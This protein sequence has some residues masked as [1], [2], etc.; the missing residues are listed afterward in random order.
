M[1]TKSLL[2]LKQKSE[3]KRL[4]KALRPK[5][6]EEF[7]GQDTIK[8]QLKVFVSAALERKEPLD[9]TL[10]YGPP[11]LGKTTLARII[12]D[13]MK[14][15]YVSTSGPAIRRKGDLAAL[16]TTLK[17]GTVLFIDEIHRLSSDLEE[18]LY[19]AM[20]DFF[21]DI[22]TGEGL[23]AQ[24]VRFHISP[25]TLIGATTRTGLLK[26][27]FRDRFGIM[28]RLD[29]Y[30]VDSLCKIVE[31]SASLLKIQLS[32]SGARE[33]AKRSRGTP[34]I[35]NHLLRRIR[36]YAQV[37]QKNCVDKEL[38]CYALE[39][40]GVNQLGLNRLDTEI[41]KTLHFDFSGS[42]VGIDTLSSA[43][44]EETDT[45]EDFYEPYLIRQGFIRKTPRGRVL[46]QKG[47][48]FISSEFKDKGKTKK[49]TGRAVLIIG[50]PKEIKNSEFR[51]GLTEHNVRQLHK[52]GHKVLVQK[53]AGRGSGISD[54]AYLEA[55]AVM[56][57]SL[58]EVYSQSEMIVKVKEPL[59][60][61][62]EL[63][64]EEQ[65]I[66]TFLHLAPEPELTSALC[67]KGVRAMA[68]ETI[69]DEQGG[70]PLLSPMSEVAGRV[71]LQN[72]VYYLQKFVGGKGILAGGVTGTEKA[73]IT[74]LGGGTAGIH[75][76]MMAVGLS[77]HVSI[78]DI[79]ENRLQY[80]SDFFKGQSVKFLVSNE[81][82]IISILKNT[83]LFIGS[84]LL[85]GHKAPKLITK[86]MIQSMSSK[87][88]VVDISIDQGGCIETARPTSHE[89]PVYNLYDIIHYCVPNIPSAVSRTSTYALTNVSLPYIKEIANKGFKEA[90]S[91]NPYLKKGL[92]VYKGHITYPPVASALNRECRLPRELGL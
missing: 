5:N 45:L 78:L 63:F 21:I 88:V 28:E 29:F 38:A 64:K 48:D 40:L 14:V 2:D 17:A 44:S 57:D 4:E 62:Y 36:D 80:L 11:G 3:D 90:L 54:R 25:F 46:T 79:D 37:A 81:K 22:V 51:V 58:E 60:E 74:I 82:N 23:G 42:P 30:D 39:E 84:V 49:T 55:G 68:Y 7:P 10:L 41:L 92:N 75:S 66:F 73:Q 56:A 89:E 83:D 34:R 16:L 67:S 24:S 31:R 61:E 18:Y 9:H 32:P 12:A 52:E 85:K 87:S 6:F 70:L 35:V 72:G 1:A 77:A 50:V 65:T 19:S 53:E 13:T 20:E 69:E 71:G 43:L 76:A 59:A 8:K 15:E 91:Q 86:E 33:I 47:Q 26:A 27:P